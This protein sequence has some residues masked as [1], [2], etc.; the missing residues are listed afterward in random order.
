M[1]M[2]SYLAEGF[3]CSYMRASIDALRKDG[4]SEISRDPPT[5]R[6]KLGEDG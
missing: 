2:R 4:S 6:L 3:A 5:K 1:H